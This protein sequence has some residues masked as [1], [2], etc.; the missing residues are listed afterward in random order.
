MQARLSLTLALLLVLAACGDERTPKKPRS[1]DVVSPTP[2]DRSPPYIYEFDF[3]GSATIDARTAHVRRAL[4]DATDQAHA[5]VLGRQLSGY[6][7][8][9]L[10]A[11]FAVT[12]LGPDASRA[13]QPTQDLIDAGA[14]PRDATPFEL[15]LATSAL[16]WARQ[17]STTSGVATPERKR[18]TAALIESAT[19]LVNAQ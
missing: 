12:F 17:R 10:R 7:T 4:D 2:S 1:T 3:L 9:A 19:R 18:M 8:A 14:P 5:S 6:G 13:I 16:T 11:W 15:A